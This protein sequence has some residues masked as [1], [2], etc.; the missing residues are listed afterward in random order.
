MDWGAWKM[1][2]SFTLMINTAKLTSF[3]WCYRDGAH[4]SAKLSEEQNYRKLQNLPSIFEFFSYV[5]FF[6][7]S[8]IGPIF[9]YKDFDMLMRKEGK[10]ANAPS[11]Y[12]LGLK[13][14]IVGILCI[15]SF[16]YLYANIVSAEFTISDEFVSHNIMWRMGYLLVLGCVIRLKFYSGFYIA[17]GSVDAVGLSYSG[18]NLGKHE[19]EGVL[20][21]GRYTEFAGSAKESLDQWNK[22]VQ[23]WLRRYVYDRLIQKDQEK[24]K[25]PNIE[26]ATS[27]TF[28]TSAFWHGIN[29]SYYLTF[30]ICWVQVEFSRNFF[31]VQQNIKLPHVVYTLIQYITTRIGFGLLLANHMLFYISKDMILMQTTWALPIVFP[32]TM[33]FLFKASGLTRKP[34]DK[35]KTQ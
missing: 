4:D 24:G 1:D 23:C 16:D 5:F 15:L 30:F 32:L 28:A 12:F 8:L 34:K 3:A 19:W 33:A 25:T 14:V 35:A 27:I 18:S 2:A 17:Q 11:G 10:F 26:S 29:P 13:M 20:T 22:S 21:C 31:R 6:P 9:E 7:C